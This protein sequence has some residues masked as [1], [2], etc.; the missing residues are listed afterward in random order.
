MWHMPREFLPRVQVFGNAKLRL[1]TAE[2][3]GAMVPPHPIH[4]SIDPSIHPSVNRP[5]RR[6]QPRSF[7]AKTRR[8]ETRNPKPHR[9]RRAP[10]DPLSAETH[11]IAARLAQARAL[12]AA[13]AK[14]EPLLHGMLSLELL[15]NRQ[16]DGSAAAAPMNSCQ[17]LTSVRRPP[18]PVP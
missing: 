3:L 1:R 16:R 8:T 11:R 10:A 12:L 15:R 4:R 18:L 13:L 14:E 6:R 9:T 17:S 5:R 2:Y 7:G